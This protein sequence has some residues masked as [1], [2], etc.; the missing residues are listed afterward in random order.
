MV[1]EYTARVPALPKALRLRCRSSAPF[2]WTTRA[3]S[4]RCSVGAGR[5]GGRCSL[6]A[7]GVS[8]RT[9]GGT[10]GGTRSSTRR[11]VGG[12]RGDVRYPARRRQQRLHAEM[13]GVIT[14]SGS[15]SPTSPAAC[16]HA[17]ALRRAVRTCAIAVTRRSTGTHP[18]RRPTRPCLH[19]RKSGTRGVGARAAGIGKRSQFSRA[20]GGERGGRQRRG[21]AGR[22]VAHPVQARGRETSRSGAG[23]HACAIQSLIAA[24]WTWSTRYS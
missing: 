22:G 1:E 21:T 24:P 11:D 15:S 4:T 3:A 18:R 2:W 13:R 19:K 23:C 6:E 7:R 20:G 8:L 9:R 12:T 16:V 5:S 10:R 14:P 17:E